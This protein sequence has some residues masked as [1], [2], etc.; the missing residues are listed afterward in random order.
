MKRR[1]I[2][3]LCSS[4]LLV[5]ISSCGGETESNSQEADADSTVAEVETQSL[6][7]D[8]Q[9]GSSYA[10]PSPNELF[11]IIKDS[12]LPYVDGLVSTEQ[13]N[14]ETS[15]EQALNFGR[16]TADIAYT[17][18]YEKFQESITNFDN[19]RKIGNDLGISYVFDEL[20]VNRFKSNMDNAD[21]L[22]VISSGTYQSIIAQLEENEK[23]STLAIIA[24]GGFVESIYLL[25]TLIG[26]YQ[27]DDE[28][29][30]RL[31]DQKLVMENVLDYLNLY[32]EEDRVI[33]VLEEVRGVSETF[34]NLEEEE[35]SESVDTEGGKVVLGGS[36]VI[37][38]EAEFN[39]L[40][41]A[42]AS[43]R[44]NFANA[45]KS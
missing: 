17:A 4:S 8:A 12:H 9:G 26:E 19:L 1:Y 13:P 28:I 22:E 24:A 39:T 11:S 45:T 41:E 27:D 10:V 18:S 6:G 36:R 21:S 14:Y 7:F 44:N 29:I 37:M 40:K 42:A 20:L 5:M 38:T 23:G 30:Q 33:E 2:S 31:A 25:T 3:L 43:Y 15:K 35:V 32:A 16:L 34:L